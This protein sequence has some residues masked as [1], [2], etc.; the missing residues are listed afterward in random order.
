MIVNSN[1]NQMN[2]SAEVGCY[3]SSGP[4]NLLYSNIDCDST[5][6]NQTMPDIFKSILTM[7]ITG[8][9]WTI[10]PCTLNIHIFTVYIL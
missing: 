10:I 6:A 9:I 8:L 2:Q 4:V 1:T 5:Q 3:F 7:C